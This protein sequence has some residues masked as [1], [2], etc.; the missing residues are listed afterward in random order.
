MIQIR[1]RMAD[2]E[3]TNPG[4]YT[5]SASQDNVTLIHVRPVDDLIDHD[6]NE[7]CVCGAQSELMTDEDFTK[8][9]VIV[10]HNSLDGRELTE[11]DYE[12]DCD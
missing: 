3:Q 10:S 2:E 5:S 11:P 1:G 4:W 12:Q 9:C 6:L 8:M 7:D